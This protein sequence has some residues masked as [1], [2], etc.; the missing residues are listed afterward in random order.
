MAPFTPFLA[1]ELYQKLTGGESVHLLDWPASG[2]VNDLVVRDMAFVREVI[3]EGL[4]QRAKH[5]VKVRQPLQS[6]SILDE[7]KILNDELQAIIIEELNV[8]EVFTHSHTETQLAVMNLALTPELKREGLM[9]EVVRHV[10]NSRKQAGLQVDDR[11]KLSLYT[12][13]KE[14]K[15][16]IGEY[17]GVIKEETLAQAFSDAKTGYTFTAN[18]KVEDSMLDISLEKA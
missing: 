13:N 8:K 5:A 9:R 4:S 10:Q 11:I 2:H 14:L 1:E 15:K 12:A 7:K 17:E 16:A 18:V 6:V 3:N